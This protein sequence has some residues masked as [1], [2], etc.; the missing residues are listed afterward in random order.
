[1]SERI[2]SFKEFW[3]YY[4]VEHAKRNC[5]ITHFVGTTLAIGV[6]CYALISRNVWLA[7]AC[8]VVGYGPA[9][10]GH[11]LIEK[12]RPASFSYPLWSLL[13]DFRMWGNM[14][15]GRFWSNRPVLEQ[16]R[17]SHAESDR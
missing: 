14:L 2:G 10:L 3:P 4:L 7:P 16:A 6:V 5:R 12:N 17:G 1:M 13:A 11:L 8:L 15:T 9:W